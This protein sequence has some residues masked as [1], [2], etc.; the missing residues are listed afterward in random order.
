MYLKGRG[1]LFDFVELK[2]KRQEGQ[3]VQRDTKRVREWGLFTLK[4]KKRKAWRLL[5]TYVH[6]QVEKRDLSGDQSGRKISHMYIFYSLYSSIGRERL[7]YFSYN[8]LD[9]NLRTRLC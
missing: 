6:R 7:F 3:I 8:G 5:R 2:R 9:P 1:K 4:R